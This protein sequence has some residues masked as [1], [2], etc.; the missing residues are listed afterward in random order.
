MRRL[1]PRVV[2]RLSQGLNLTSHSLC[3]YEL[4]GKYVRRVELE[5]TAKVSRKYFTCNVVCPITGLGHCLH[6]DFESLHKHH[7]KNHSEA[8]HISSREV[9]CLICGLVCPKRKHWPCTIF[10]NTNGILRLFSLFKLS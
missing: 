7:V 5:S 1:P 9:T 4:I 8:N 10:K 6:C 2:H 3:P